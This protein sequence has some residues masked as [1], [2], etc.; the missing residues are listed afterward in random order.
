MKLTEFCWLKWTARSIVG[1]RALEQ[2]PDGN[3]WK[4]H[5]GR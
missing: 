1:R 2:V 3:D 4:P 5:E